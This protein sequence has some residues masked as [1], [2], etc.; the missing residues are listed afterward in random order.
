MIVPQFLRFY[1]GYTAQSV[2]EES[3][4]TF[5]ALVNAMFRLKALEQIDG[6]TVVAIGNAEPVNRNEAMTELEKA[7]K[8]IHG[9]VEEVRL[10]RS[11]RGRIS[12]RR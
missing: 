12:K 10:V 3:A 2:L 5:F 6:I 1:Q 9:R 8:G 7:S 11:L 4:K